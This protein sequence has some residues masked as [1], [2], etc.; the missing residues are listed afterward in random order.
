MAER[1]DIK[2]EDWMRAQ[3]LRANALMGRRVTASWSNDGDSIRL[4]DDN[5][6]PVST[7]CFVHVEGEVVGWQV[8]TDRQA[9]VTIAGYG[10]V[11]VDDVHEVA[12]AGPWWRRV[13]F[14]LG[15]AEG[16]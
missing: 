9:T 5:T 3:R 8:S 2:L 16:I 13:A 4:N 15:L 7:P 11:A 6:E 10:R 14:Y 1:V 12:P